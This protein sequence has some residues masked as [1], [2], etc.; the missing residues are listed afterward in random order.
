MKVLITGSTANQSNPLTHQRATNFAGC[1]YDALVMAGAQVDWQEPSVLSGKLD[2]SQYD[3]VL[4]GVASPMALGS[5]RLYGALSIVASLWGTPRLALFADAPEPNN[6]TRGLDSIAR[7]PDAITKD[8]FKYRKDFSVAQSPEI[9]QTILG[10]CELLRSEE[11]PTTIVPGFPWSDELQ[12]EKDLPVGAI[13][14][15]VMV[16]LDK[17]I[18]RKMRDNVP[19]E[20]S[21]RESRWVAEKTADRKWLRNLHV[22]S[23]IYPLKSDHRVD[24]H[25]E[26]IHSLRTSTGFLHSP[27]KRG[28]LWWTPKLATSLSQKTPVFTKWEESKLLGEEWSVLP[29]T[30]EAF[31]EEARTV[32]A[33]AQYDSYTNTIPSTGVLTYNLCKILGMEEMTNDTNR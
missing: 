9:R 4:V 17:F 32:L 22:S 18:F 3:K 10:A 19:N 11:W 30:F 24:I 28:S 15:V 5:N 23:P 26:L 31:P 12:Y 29:S 20:T 2:L 14:R 7:N 25:P 1:L 13:D 33:Q 27:S 6:I 8:F 16:N 21:H